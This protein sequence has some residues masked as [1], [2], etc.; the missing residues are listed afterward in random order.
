M[1]QHLL[2][3]TQNQE[4]ALKQELKQAQKQAAVLTMITEILQ[5]LRGFNFTPQ[6]TC[7]NCAHQFTRAQILWGFMDDDTD[8]RVQ[9][10]RCNSTNNGA[11][12]VDQA[13]EYAKLEVPFYC[14]RQVVYFFKQHPELAN[15]PPQTIEKRHPAYAASAMIHFG[16]YAT[17]FRNKELDLPYAFGEIASWEHKVKQFLGKVPDEIIAKCVGVSKKVVAKRRED[18]KIPAYQQKKS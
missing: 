2:L 15:L 1:G 10:P 4:L 14:Y 11:I 9:C 7:A 5:S 6:A 3:T 8:A 13:H 17:L 18:L 16:N 12:L